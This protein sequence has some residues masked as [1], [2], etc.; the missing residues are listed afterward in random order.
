MAYEL[1]GKVIPAPSSEYGKTEITLQK[2]SLLFE[3]VHSKTNVFMSHNDQVMPSSGRLR[4]NLV[5]EDL[6]ERFF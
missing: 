4:Q 3:N 1:G 2:S 6:P 5:L